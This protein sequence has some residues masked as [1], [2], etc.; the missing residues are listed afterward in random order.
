MSNSSPPL[1]SSAAKA[2]LHFRLIGPSYYR[3]ALLN[4]QDL[5]ILS[6][7][8]P[9]SNNSFSGMS[10]SEAAGLSMASAWSLLSAER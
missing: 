2:G 6:P 7:P 10:Q 4:R 1:I 5:T 8:P 9:P 3:V